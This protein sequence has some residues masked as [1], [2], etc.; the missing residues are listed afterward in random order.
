MPPRV[1]RVLVIGA[2]LASSAT[3]DPMPEYQVKAAFLANFLSFIRWPDNAQPT[4]VC[5]LGRDPFGPVLEQTL[6]K[7]APA[8]QIRRLGIGQSF[9]GCH[10]LFVPASESR[11]LAEILPAASASG[12]LT[13]G[14]SPDFLSSGGLVAL[15]SDQNRIRIDID[16]DA[17]QR[18]RFQFSSR[19]LSVA[20]LVK[21]PRRSGS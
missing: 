7:S 3:A 10:L 19:L 14:E 21:A 11:R 17:V 12:I 4:T 16:L 18:S 6:S 15:T 20:H 13:I 5:L 2:L 1:L 9:K 8:A